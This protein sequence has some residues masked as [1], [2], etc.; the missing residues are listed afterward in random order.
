MK[1]K[2]RVSAS[3][4]VAP[5][6]SGKGRAQ[7]PRLEEGAESSHV[8]AAVHG[9]QASSS[10][11]NSVNPTATAASSQANP[12]K[13]RVSRK[14]S[15][16][17]E[18]GQVV[19]GV[20]VGIRTLSVCRLRLPPGC[21]APLSVVRGNGATGLAVRVCELSTIDCWKAD[22][23]T[24][25]TANVR[26]CASTLVLDGLVCYFEREGAAFFEGADAIVIEAQMTARMKMLSA[27]IYVIA[28]SWAPSARIS[29]Q[30]AARKLNFGD[31]SEL[32]PGMTKQTYA[33]RKKLAVCLTREF[34]SHFDLGEE[35]E[36]KNAAAHDAFS[37]SKKRDDYADS[38]LHALSCLVGRV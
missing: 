23:I 4:R 11:P 26:V 7:R 27:A 25:S 16:A 18:A 21:A 37:T 10:T 1:R 38:F 6:K 24:T 9:G 22:E 34:L 19:V 15:D 36:S 33:Q 2:G 30:S 8:P 32:A 3:D 14:K 17:A 31:F 29:F 20:D 12:P 5:A 35:D 13:R 28:R